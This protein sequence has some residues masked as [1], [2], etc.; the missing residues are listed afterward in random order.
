MFLTHSVTV[1]QPFRIRQFGKE[2][3][4]ARLEVKAP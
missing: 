2:S 4:K 3:F 1:N